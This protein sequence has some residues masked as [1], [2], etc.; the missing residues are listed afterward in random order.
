MSRRHRVLFY[1][2]DSFG[3]GH[4]RRSLTIASYLS[5][6]I[7]SLSVLMLTGFESPAAFEAPAGIDFVKLPSIWKAG[8]DEYRSRHLRVS[9]KRVV[10]MREQMIRTVVRA[11]APSMV[12]VDNVPRGIDG[13][14]LP[15]LRYLR[16]QLPHTR[17]VLT[18]RDVL[19]APENVVP[20]WRSL[21][22][23]GV[24]ERF[25]DEIWV[26]G[27]A[28]VFDPVRL[29]EMPPQIAEKVRYCGYVVRWSPA[30]Q[31]EEIRRELDL[32]NRR[33]VVASCGGGGDGA[34]L[35]R[36]FVDAAAPL[37]DQGVLS[38]VFLGPDMPAAERRELKQRLLPLSRAFHTFDF[39]PDLVSFLSAA[40]CSV[41]MAGYNT[42][43]EITA[44]GIP[45]IVVP[46]EYPR[47]EQLL[48]AQ[49]FA[50]RGL[51][52]LLPQSELSPESLRRLL[53]QV[54]AQAA[55]HPRRDLPPDVDFA[56]LSRIARRVRKHLGIAATA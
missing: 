23:Y 45:A 4:F 5:R 40:T 11:F 10:R 51:L 55:V 43:C 19:D 29:Y 26:V 14:L 38:A 16:K 33:L 8:P 20:Q 12:V 21:D 18:L 13:E 31:I 41:S 34:P 25:Y 22:V 44:R 27:S 3:L 36:A 54:L 46:R 32:G 42:M 6:H 17:I 28:A 37:A 48:R 7:D 35:L 50:D 56:G 39:R 49:A 9:F 1:S 15:M 52:D 2:H 30:G 53:G 47:Y 24:L